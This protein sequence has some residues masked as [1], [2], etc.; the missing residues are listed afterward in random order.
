VSLAGNFE[1]VVQGEPFTAAE[2]HEYVGLGEVAYVAQKSAEARHY[3]SAHPTAFIHL[4]LR[5]FLRF[6]TGRGTQARSH[7]FLLGCLPQPTAFP[8]SHLRGISR[9]PGDF[10]AM[11][12]SNRPLAACIRPIS[13]ASSDTS[14]GGDVELMQTVSSMTRYVPTNNNQEFAY[15]ASQAKLHICMKN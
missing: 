3:I 12:D 4:T 2:F 14:Y 1:P 10:P 8:P 11:A 9:P 13:A 6:W 7:I 15:D 5:R